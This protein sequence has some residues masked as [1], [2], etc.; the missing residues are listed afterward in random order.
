LFG[1]WRYDF[2]VS[3]A[4]KGNQG[5]ARSEPDMPTTVYGRDPGVVLKS[6]FGRVEVRRGDDEMVELVHGRLT[7]H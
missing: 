2:Q 5:V 6:L 3:T 1:V 7:L 4:A